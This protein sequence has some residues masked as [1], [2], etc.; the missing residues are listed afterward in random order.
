MKVLVIAKNEFKR[1]FVTPLGW[2]IMAIVIVVMTYVFKDHLASF[3]FDFQPKM[4]KYANPPGITDYVVVRTIAY[5]AEF[6]M[7]IVPIVAMN[8]FAEE[9]KNQT[10][11]LLQSSPISITE[12]VL[13]KYLGVLG[14]FALLILIFASMIFMF[15]FETS[16]DIGKIISGLIGICLLVML[17]TAVTIFFSSIT[18]IPL[19]AAVVSI[20]IIRFFWD[21]NIDMS[22]Y[23]ETE[24]YRQV[25]EV[26]FYISTPQRFGP[27]LMGIMQTSDILYFV[28]FSAMFLM[29]TIKRL[30]SE[31]IRL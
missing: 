11:A 2:S 1:Q 8:S 5:V 24:M 29:F 3:L 13:G 28:I 19:L 25:G 7:W 14:V 16:L 20:G 10:L 9:R 22:G 30:D 12:I 23:P 21:L 18:R 26:L 6:L 27:M 15:Q 17:W 4:Y 31:R